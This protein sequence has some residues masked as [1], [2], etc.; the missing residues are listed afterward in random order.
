VSEELLHIFAKAEQVKLTNQ[1]KLSPH[2][3]QIVQLIEKQDKLSDFIKMW[4][5]NFLEK[6]E[7]QHLPVGWRV[8]HKT[9]RKFGEY[10]TF[11]K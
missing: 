4:R 2:G 11:K 9:E 8:E 7:P 6:N 10:S 5:T 3:R 1:Q